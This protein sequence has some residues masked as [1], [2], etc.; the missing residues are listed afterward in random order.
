MLVVR[1]PFGEYAIVQ[2]AQLR[3]E[4]RVRVL[5]SPSL[6]SALVSGALDDPRTRRALFAFARIDGAHDRFALERARACVARALRDG[7]LA[8]LDRRAR[9][10][11]VEGSPR[12]LATG[13]GP[14]VIEKSELHFV[15]FDATGAPLPS[16]YRFR[17]RLPQGVDVKSSLDEN[18]GGDFLD[19]DAGSCLLSFP[20]VGD[21]PSDNVPDDPMCIALDNAQTV[22]RSDGDRI[23]NL[24]TRVDPYF[25]QIARR[26][27]EVIELEHFRPSSAVMLPGAVPAEIAMRS[28]VAPVLGIEVLK[29]CRVF[30]KDYPVDRTRITGHGAILSQERADCVKAL[31]TADRD[32][33]VDLALAHGE[34]GDVQHVL[35]W[36]A[37]QYRWPCDPGAIT[38][39]NDSATSRAVWNFQTNYNR[40]FHQHIDVDGIV[41]PQTWGAI[42]D[43]YQRALTPEPAPDRSTLPY[44]DVHYGKNFVPHIVAHDATGN[45]ADYV[46]MNPYNPTKP[47][48]GDRGWYP[49][50]PGE[51][52]LLPPSWDGSVESLVAAGWHAFHGGP[53]AP[54]IVDPAP[55]PMTKE[56]LRSIGCGDHHL[57]GP[58]GDGAN[59]RAVERRV[60]VLFFDEGETPA[61]ICTAGGATPCPSSSCELY[62]AREYV[63]EYVDCTGGVPVAPG[64]VTFRVVRDDGSAAA[65]VELI[66]AS[67]LDRMVH[68]IADARGEARFHVAPGE[69]LE[70][71]D[72]VD[73]DK[74]QNVVHAALS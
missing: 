18:G 11:I 59:R 68:G 67:T 3:A 45:D 7:E 46:Q 28:G 53:P 47:I 38:E 9:T 55:P 69:L 19:I 72:V 60:E 36:V 73:T 34:I 20:N 71:L 25:F 33:F 6:V 16:T 43:C 12:E 30:A 2:R 51:R 52:V 29:A 74:Q 1:T 70:L 56:G 57:V 64:L 48:P 23:F 61:L 49:T 39:V 21:R 26:E 15:I 58:F 32:A 22:E 27:A 54:P 13:L 42:F 66:V 31:L 62:D 40:E 14:E 5:T 24:G 37:P 63:F 41:G 8:M 10:F 44:I 17:V 4:D 50:Y 35:R 65:G